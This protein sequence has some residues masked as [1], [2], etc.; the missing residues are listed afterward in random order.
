MGPDAEWAVA[1]L[2]KLT[3][4]PQTHIRALSAR[5]LGEIGITT[6]QVQS[7]LKKLLRDRELPVRQTAET[8]LEQL[9]SPLASPAN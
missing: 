8:A 3:S 1:T 6:D 9:R 4:H 7:T 2:I 5:A